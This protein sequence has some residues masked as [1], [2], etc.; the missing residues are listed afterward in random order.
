[1][2]LLFE[3]KHEIKQEKRALEKCFISH[4]VTNNHLLNKFKQDIKLAFYT[5][6]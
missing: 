1:M 5:S 3:M 2:N 6:F 4:I